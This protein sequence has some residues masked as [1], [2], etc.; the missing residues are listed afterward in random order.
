MKTE[1]LIVG[2]G[3]S[4][5][6]AATRLLQQKQ[7]FLLVEGRDRMGGRIL[8]EAPES[9]DGSN[10]PWAF[11]LGPTWY[12]P[13]QPRMARL[14]RELGVESFQ[15]FSSGASRYEDPQRGVETF[16]NP[17]MTP[18]S[19]RVAGGMARVIDALTGRLPP[20]RLRRSSRVTG[21]TKNG[22]K[23]E[24]SLQTAGETQVIEAERVLLALPPRVALRSIK[25][26]P[27]LPQNLR[28]ALIAIP[29]WMAGHAKVV[30]VYDRPFWR[31]QG[32]S[33][34]AF[35]HVGPAMEIH[36]ASPPEGPGALFGFLGIPAEQRRSIDPEALRSAAT[37][38]FERLF[39][40]EAAQP[41]ALFLKDWVEDPLT[42]TADDLAPLTS[43]PRYG[44]PPAAQKIWDG[45]LVFCATEAAS[46]QGGFLEGALVAAE[47]ATP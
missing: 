30:A 14:L 40:P 26:I 25:L 44:L 15:Q 27:A 22:I 12:W 31:T 23:L 32:L 2:G 43:H 28:E 42:A 9:H 34:H 35:S 13:D 7:D 16:R 33:G 1:T 37:A 29:T 11:D 17:G 19:L 10:V 4:G 36:D 20:E 38:Q 45:Q 46:R 18:V 24:V 5:L 6:Y 21:I 39:G 41:K 3:L 47:E 8:S